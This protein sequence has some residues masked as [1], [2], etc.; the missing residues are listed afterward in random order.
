M[1][2]VHSAAR[3]G[4]PWRVATPERRAVGIPAGVLACRIGKR[5]GGVSGKRFVVEIRKAGR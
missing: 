2:P 5:F 3:G 1:S 4:F